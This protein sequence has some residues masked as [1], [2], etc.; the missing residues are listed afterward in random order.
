QREQCIAAGASLVDMN[1]LWGVPLINAALNYHDAARVF[2]NIHPHTGQAQNNP[3][4]LVFDHTFMS[5][6]PVAGSTPGQVP[7]WILQAESLDVLVKLAGIE[8]GQ[9]AVTVE[10]STRTR[11]EGLMPNSAVALPNRIVT[12][13]TLRAASPR[14]IIPESLSKANRKYV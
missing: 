12:W 8:A 13:A 4:W 7:A 1:A 9:L 3:A 5:K 11:D 6:Y 2:A 14:P 10:K